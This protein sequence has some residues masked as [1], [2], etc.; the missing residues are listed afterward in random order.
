MKL[1]R[2][3]SGSRLAEHLCR[4]WGYRVVHQLGSHIILETN[5]PTQHKLSV[6]DHTQV[7]VGTLAAILR[8]VS[9]HKGVG[10]EDVLREY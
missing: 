3:I 7:R 6:P 1:P 2:D 5:Q 8:S 10:R 4:R 9:V